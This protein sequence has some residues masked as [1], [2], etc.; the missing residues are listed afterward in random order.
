MS[1]HTTFK[2]LCI[3]QILNSRLI[4]FNNDGFDKPCFQHTLNST[5][6][7]FNK[8]FLIFLFV[9]V[10][11]NEIFITTAVGQLGAVGIGPYYQA[12]GKTQ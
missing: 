1:C 9:F 6:I 3:Q 10:L 8:W 2:T 5:T 4:D 12:A 11:Q 7:V